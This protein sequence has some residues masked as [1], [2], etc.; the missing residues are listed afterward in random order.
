MW[1]SKI[2]LLP[3]PRSHDLVDEWV[4][5][6]ET[7]RVMSV[8]RLL[9]LWLPWVTVLTGVNQHRDIILSRRVCVCVCVFVCAPLYHSLSLQH[10]ISPD[11]L[12][13]GESFPR[14][15]TRGSYGSGS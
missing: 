1:Q 14:G 9:Q 6:L 4:W 10:Y 11:H 2:G 5:F 12:V 7:A 3:L 13:V 8:S 15:K